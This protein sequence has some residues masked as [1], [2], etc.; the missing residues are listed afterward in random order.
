M[1]VAVA[2]AMPQ[3]RRRD[4]ESDDV[5][6]RFSTTTSARSKVDGQRLAAARTRLHELPLHVEGRDVAWTRNGRVEATSG[7]SALRG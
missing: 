7:M 3:R 5:S 4:A 2:P 6:W 1:R